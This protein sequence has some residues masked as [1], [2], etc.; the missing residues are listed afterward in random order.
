MFEMERIAVFAGTT[1]G[2]RIAEFLEDFPVQVF[3]SIATEYG[4][5]SLGTYRNARV[6][7]GRMEQE[8]MEAFLEQNQIDLVVD[9]THPFAKI[10]TENL[11]NACQS[12]QT[13]Y[14]RCLREA[15]PVGQGTGEESAEN[16][17]MT[18]RYVEDGYIAD[19]HMRE[20]S[21]EGIP[22]VVTVGCVR[23]AVAFL[24]KT[25]GNILITTGSKELKEY[26]AIPDYRNRCYARVLST[27]QA[28]SESAALGFEGKHLIAM[29]GPFSREMNVALLQ[30][31]GAAY[32]VTK[33]S[34]KAGGFPEKL[35]AAAEAGAVLVVI[36]RPEE[37]GMTLAEVKTF[38][39]NWMRPDGE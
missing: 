22:K 8:Q 10:V 25:S 27:V 18:D 32:F 5:D 20:G 13:E 38:L 39:G 3:I 36:G 24:K 34:G 21:L 29:Q 37:D 30:H 12:C 15:L 19:E 33:E 6:L 2:R 9:A 4:R 26:T 11:R 31:I 1:E 23:E 28:V 16:D 7:C 14:I 35:E 17:Y